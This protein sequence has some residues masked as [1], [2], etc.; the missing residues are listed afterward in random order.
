MNREKIKAFYREIGEA[1][2]GLT[3]SGVAFYCF[4]GIFPFLSLCLSLYQ[5]FFSGLEINEHEFFQFIPEV[6]LKF[7]EQQLQGL[8]KPLYFSIGT[9]LSL[10]LSIW[11]ASLALKGLTAGLNICYELKEDRKI[12]KKNLFSFLGTIA[13][14]FSIFGFLFLSSFLPVLIKLLWIDKLGSLAISTVNLLFTG[15]LLFLFFLMMYQKLPNHKK[16]VSLRK[17]APGS[18]LSC[19]FFLFSS[20]GFTIY[21]THFGNY[22]AI[23]GALSSVVI[24]LIWIRLTVLVLLFGAKLNHYL[25]PPNSSLSMG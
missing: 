11:T 3:A 17:N 2:L 19:L 21:L 1:R 4:L 13:L 5:K 10:G 25:S 20:Y 14:A 23:Y 9:A 15:S 22:N 8:G 6:I 12:F 18:L 16:K 24:L 7:L